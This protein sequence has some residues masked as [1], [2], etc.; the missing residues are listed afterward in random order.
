[1]KVVI[2]RVLKAKVTKAS[3]NEVVGE[4]GPGLFILVGIKNT[5][6]VENARIIS[7]K[8]LKMRIMADNDQKMNLNIKDSNGEILIVSQF[9]L[10]SNTKDGNRPSFIDAANPFD[11]RK[12]Y[13]S[14][15]DQLKESKLKIET[16]SFG[17]YMKIDAELDGPVTIVLEN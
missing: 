9:T 5:D 8:I 6:S 15:I 4:I 1:M 10:Y 3:T 17:E 13:E 7:S 12:I 16:G 14:F 11:A 2:Q